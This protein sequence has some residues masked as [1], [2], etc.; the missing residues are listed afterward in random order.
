MDIT[1]LSPE[2]AAAVRVLVETQLK[3]QI[4]GLEGRG[5]VYGGIYAIQWTLCSF[6]RERAERLAW[7]L[8]EMKFTQLALQERTVPSEVP[9]VVDSYYSLR[10]SRPVPLLPD[11]LVGEA[12]VLEAVG[13]N[14]GAHVTGLD[15][16]TLQDDVVR[17]MRSVHGPM[18]GDIC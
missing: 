10:V 15:L 7:L 5:C 12:L 14:W 2:E 3:A 16:P 13:V 9:G 18:G 4:D 17:A 6:D 11:A 1:Q 8:S